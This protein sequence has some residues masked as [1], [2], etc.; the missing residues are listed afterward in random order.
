[1]KVAGILITVFAPFLFLMGFLGGETSESFGII[2]ILMSVYLLIA[3]LI[4]I[5]MEKK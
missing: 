5:A 3:G 1:M 2:A 4:L